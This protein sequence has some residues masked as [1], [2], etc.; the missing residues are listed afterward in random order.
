VRGSCLQIR[1]EGG[2]SGIGMGEPREH[3][4]DGASESD[5]GTPGQML[6]PEATIAR[7]GV[8][9]GYRDMRL[10]TI[11]PSVPQMRNI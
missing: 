6:Q 10:E 3:G 5:V 7:D 11:Y 8:L 9:A 2:V 1:A 4:S